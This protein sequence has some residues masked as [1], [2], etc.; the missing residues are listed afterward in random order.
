MGKC[1]LFHMLQGGMILRDLLNFSG[2]D[3]SIHNNS[4]LS[5]VTFYLPAVISFLRPALYWPLAALIVVLGVVVSAVPSQS[6]GVAGCAQLASHILVTV[7][8]VRT[9][10]GSIV[11]DLLADN[12]DHILKKGMKISRTRVSA[13]FDQ[14]RLCVPVE[15]YGTYAIAVYHD[16]NG[17]RKFDKNWL[18]FPKEPFGLS[19]NPRIR[20]RVPKFSDL[21][22]EVGENGADVE[23]VL[24][25]WPSKK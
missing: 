16:I 15:T 6:L 9:A 4:R 14:V 7:Q 24:K 18:G 13:A 5:P 1:L 17:N 21:S 25:N 23:I 19:N 22:F 11:V 10:S 20:L 3:P 12:P 2:L 8:D